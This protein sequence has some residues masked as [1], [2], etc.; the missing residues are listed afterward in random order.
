VKTLRPICLLALAL[1]LID[2]GL[3][4]HSVPVNFDQSR[5][6][7]VEGVLTDVKWLNPHSH[8]RM[9]VT[10]EDGSSVEWLVEMGSF[11]AMKRSG[12]ETHLFD[13]GTA[14]T[15]IGWPGRRERTVY[16]T[17]ALVPDGEDV[18]CVRAPTSQS[19]SGECGER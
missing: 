7:D 3:A 10:V 14:V 4:H 11:N 18:K 19:P 1:I 8:F 2:A 5:Q 16:L 12:F 13:V 9:D 15:V 6:I 17:Q